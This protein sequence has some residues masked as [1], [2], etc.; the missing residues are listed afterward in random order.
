VDGLAVMV[1]LRHELP[2]G[3][4]HFDWLLE[5]PGYPDLMTFRVRERIDLLGPGEPGGFTA[6]RLEDHRRAYLTYEGPISGGRGSVTRVAEGTCE[7]QEGPDGVKILGSFGLGMTAYEGHPVDSAGDSEGIWQ[8]VTSVDQ[9]AG[10][11]PKNAP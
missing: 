6:T 2:D 5:R 4:G 11:H 10:R 9:R 3:P 1:L 8:F 7:V